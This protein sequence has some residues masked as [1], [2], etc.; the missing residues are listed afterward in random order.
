MNEKKYLFLDD[1]RMPEQ[2]SLYA[3]VGLRDM[4][5]QVKWD[6]VRNYDEFVKYISD[7][8]LPDYISFDHDLAEIH[9]DPSTWVEGFEYDEKTGYD[10]AKWLLE[11]PGILDNK[12]LTIFCHSQNPV[13]KTKILNLFKN[14]FN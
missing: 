11:Q 14:K 2:V 4:Y 3:E 6:I 10:C 9:Y 1:V 5:R 12:I 7:K 13:G 8:G